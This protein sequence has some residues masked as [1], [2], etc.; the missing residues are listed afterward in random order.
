MEYKSPFSLEGKNILVT[1][2]SSG[3]GL[4]ICK[5]VVASGGKVIGVARREGMLQEMTNELGF[6]KASYIHADLALDEGIAK[7]V[8]AMPEVNGVVCAA[9][10]AKMLPLKFIKRQA[11]EEIL[12]IN[13][14]SIVL[15]LSQIVRQKKIRKND[16]SSIVLISS[17]AQQIGTKS[18]LLYTGSKAA[19]SAAGRVIA[20][21]LSSQK[22]RVNS[23]EPGMVQTAMASE[24]E[25]VVSRESIDKDK[26][27][28]PLGYGTAADVANA[29]VFLLAE[30]SKWMTGQ[31]LTLDGGRYK[32]ID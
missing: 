11:L 19:L 25:D 9:G 29:T 28:Y 2:A 21:E 14:F 4:N 23:I 27:K 7:V 8:D 32:L 17:V 30:A 31:S 15:L 12:N 3:I 10:I 5:A 24:M 13:Y 1:G 26:E 16:N 20:N 18:S 6:D 22:I